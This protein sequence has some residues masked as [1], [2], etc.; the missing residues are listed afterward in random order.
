MLIIDL[1]HPVGIPGYPN[2]R[3]GDEAATCCASF[4]DPFDGLL[5][6]ELE[7]EPA[8]LS[9]HCR[10]L[11]LFDMGGHGRYKVIDCK[12]LGMSCFGPEK[13]VL[14]LLCCVYM[15]L[16]PA[17]AMEASGEWC[18]E[19]EENAACPA[20]KWKGDRGSLGLEMG[21]CKWRLS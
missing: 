3:E 5:D 17:Q 2:F 20:R 16:S 12:R 11:V 1:P 13:Y 9:S 21:Q 14:G 10:G 19:D 8:G 4:V 15:G 18:R 7:V 6:G